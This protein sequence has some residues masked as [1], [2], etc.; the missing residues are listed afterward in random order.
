[1]NE[2]INQIFSVNK[3]SLVIVLEHDSEY[4]GDLYNLQKVNEK[5]YIFKSKPHD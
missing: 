5:L 2:E 1:M 3:E 4:E